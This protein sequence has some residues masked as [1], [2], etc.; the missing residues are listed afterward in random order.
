MQNEAKEAVNKLE[1]ECSKLRKELKESAQNI[2]TQKEA[3]L[4]EKEVYYTL[5]TFNDI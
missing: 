3:A 5:L 4:M 2:H 1:K